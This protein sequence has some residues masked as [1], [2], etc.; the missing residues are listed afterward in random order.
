MA[1]EALGAATVLLIL[2]LVGFGIDGSLPQYLTGSGL[3]GLLGAAAVVYL[4]VLLAMFVQNR[5]R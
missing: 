1:K 5:R 2:A 4:I 3:V